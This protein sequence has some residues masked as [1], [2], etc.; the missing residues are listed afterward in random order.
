MP[1]IQV[2]RS[3]SFTAAANRLGVST[4]AVS[5]SIARL[6]NQ[7]DTRLFNRTT[8][9]IHLT[10][11]GKLFFDHVDAGFA[12]IDQAINLVEEARGGPVGLIRLSTMTYFGRHLLMP[13]VPTFL[14]TFPNVSL[15]I[16]MNDIMPDLVSEGFDVRI[17]H[18][19]PTETRYVYRHLYRL[20]LV[21]VASPEYLSRKGEPRHPDDLVHHDCITAL[22]L[23]GERY[24]WNFTAETSDN[25][26]QQSAS[27]V[28]YPN[29]RLVVSKQVDT[30]VDAALMGLGVTVTFVESVLEHLESGRLQVLLPDF[31]VDD[32]GRNDSEIFIQYPHREY[33]SLKVRVLIDFLI[34]HF[35]S[36][37]LRDYSPA[38]LKQ[39]YQPGA[40]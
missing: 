26:T 3:G 13:L 34:E 39:R 15:E 12:R 1:F 14:D 40:G 9:S 11:E 18:G 25:A 35:Y 2:A 10:A 7:L 6:E 17:I 22:R 16:S 37:E 28:H 27:Y 32:D 33:L 19:Q 38:T 20:P 23:S 8:R 24:S 31:L 36:Y 5:K 4:A 21:L 29:G 30:V